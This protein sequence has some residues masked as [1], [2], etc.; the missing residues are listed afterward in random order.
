[1]E[2][3][4]FLND[5]K[6]Y[7]DII[8]VIEKGDDTWPGFNHNLKY[9]LKRNLNFKDSKIFLIDTEDEK[10]KKLNEFIYIYFRDTE[11]KE[12]YR[13]INTFLNEDYIQIKTYKD[14][15]IKAVYFKKKD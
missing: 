11:K 6:K 9:F 10:M 8:F 14:Y 1:V 3:K 2:L 13:R 15:Q 7:H 5:T 4:G 12:G